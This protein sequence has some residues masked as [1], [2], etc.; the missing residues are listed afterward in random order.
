[1]TLINRIALAI[2]LLAFTGLASAQEFREGT[3]YFVIESRQ[4]T[5]T[6]DAVEVVDVFSYACP[7]CNAFK[8]HMDALKKELPD[9]VEVQRVAAPYAGFFEVMARV[10]FALDVMGDVD[11]VH[12]ELFAAIHQR[13]QRWRSVEQVADFLNDYGVDGE[14]LNATARSFAVA[15][16]MRRA[17]QQLGRYGAN[18]V[19]TVIVNGK[20]RV[21]ITGI[22]AARMADTIN[23]LIQQELAAN[24][25]AEAGAASSE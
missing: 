12:D 17:Q 6:S 24:T 25:G 3:D 20:Y 2:S 16:R 13:G 14:K 18:G 8:P 7:A 23:Y 19:P 10:F 4:P 11:K 15:S 5:S 21:T 1:M 9:G 22:G